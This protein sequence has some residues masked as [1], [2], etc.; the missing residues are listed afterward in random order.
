MDD[1]ARAAIRAEIEKDPAG[2]GY[3]SGREDGDLALVAELLIT[4]PRVRNPDPAPHVPAPIDPL[5]LLAA[6][7]DEEYAKIPEATTL[8]VQDYLDSGDRGRLAVVVASLAKR[9]VLSAETVRSL[10]AALST[11]VP[12]PSWPAEVEGPNRAS[13]VL[14]RALGALSVEDLREVLA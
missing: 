11:T 1:D 2:M 3:P 7:P 6:I 14:G 5:A 10:R 13:V 9:G 12:D 4:P 8:R